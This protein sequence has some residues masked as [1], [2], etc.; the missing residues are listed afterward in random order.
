[1]LLKDL[2]ALEAVEI[3]ALLALSLPPALAHE[4]PQCS[5]TFSMQVLGETLM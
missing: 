3:R 2:A 4:A 1:M 5:L